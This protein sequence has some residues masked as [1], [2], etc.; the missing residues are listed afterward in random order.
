MSIPSI[1]TVNRQ[2]VPTSGIVEPPA[3]RL[4]AQNVSVGYGE[5]AIINHLSTA[6]PTGK[7]TVIIGPNA[8]GKSTLLRALARLLRPTTGSVVLDGEDIRRCPTKQVARRLGLLPQSPIA[9]EG[10]LVRDLI[11]RGRTPHQSIF[12]QWSTAD[13]AAV[14]AALAD[15]GTAELAD[16]PDRKSVV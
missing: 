5:R 8:S 1:P 2:D 15:T 4:A 10:I 12:R 3:S 11:G 7:I 6:I 14:D 9:P 16:R 13:A